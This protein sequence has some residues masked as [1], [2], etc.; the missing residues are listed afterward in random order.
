MGTVDPGSVRRA[1]D[2]HEHRRRDV[3]Q[4]AEVLVD[5]WSIEF[6]KREDIYAAV[7]E[8][9]ATTPELDTLQKR[10]LD[11]TMRDY[12]R[13]GMDLSPEDRVR[14]IEIEK[15]LAT[16]GQEFNRTIRE[17]DSTVLL[18]AEDLEHRTR[19]LLE[20]LSWRC[21]P[22]EYRGPNRPSGAGP[23]PI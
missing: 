13:A 1:R 12:R 8:Y 11:E 9:A 19:R 17:D 23:D 10:M 7:K 22:A 2:L 15:E 18:T 16:L 4:A 5:N 20:Y 14:L 6:G 3:G 21:H